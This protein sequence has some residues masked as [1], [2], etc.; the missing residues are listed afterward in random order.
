M[1]Q[2]VTSGLTPLPIYRSPPPLGHQLGQLHPQTHLPLAVRLAWRSPRRPLTQ[3]RE[4]FNWR[5]PPRSGAVVVDPRASVWKIRLHPAGLSRGSG[6]IN[7]IPPTTV[8]HNTKTHLRTLMTPMNPLTGLSQVLLHLLWPPAPLA[9]LPSHPSD[10]CRVFHSAS[11]RLCI[12]ADTSSIYIVD[13]FISLNAKA[14]SSSV[15]VLITISHRKSKASDY[16]SSDS[17]IP[18]VYAYF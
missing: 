17:T 13:H 3:K 8:A 2:R 1:Q 16:G 5:P 12:W 18:F 4:K 11:P 6:L 15:S 9:T 10:R 14:E 7:L